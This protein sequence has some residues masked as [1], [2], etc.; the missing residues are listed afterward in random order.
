[1]SDIR[2]DLFKSFYS[3]SLVTPA[4][5]KYYFLFLDDSV[6]KEPSCSSAEHQNS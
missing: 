6:E 4:T 3:D 5:I 1:M 2:N